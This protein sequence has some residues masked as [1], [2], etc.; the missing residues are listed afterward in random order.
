[1]LE[2]GKCIERRIYISTIYSG[3]VFTRFN[4]ELFLVEALDLVL[5]CASVEE[6]SHAD[7]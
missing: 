4:V 1:M 7:L 2:I 3:D 6:R 5:L